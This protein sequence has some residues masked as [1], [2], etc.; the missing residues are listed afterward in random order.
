MK[1]YNILILAFVVVIIVTSCASRKHYS[2]EEY[3][4]TSDFEK[5][6]GRY[7][8]DR[9][10]LYHFFNI[11]ASD[12]YPESTNRHYR[13]GESTGDILGP[14][15]V[16]E[17]L[18][19]DSIGLDFILLS[20]NGKD[21]LNIMYRDSDFWY[22]KS[23]RG[24]IKKNYFEIVLQNKRYPFFPIISRHDVDKI[25]VGLSQSRDLLVHNYSEHWGTFLLFG[26]HAGGDEYFISL[27][28][29]SE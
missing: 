7:F 17:E 12:Y 25:R 20:F 14:T 23:Y 21:S 10:S 2:S 19:Q 22:K 18:P 15:T 3:F 29:L 13:V 11:K 16:K 28:R 1:D 24:K 9:K 8:M 4:I 26:A 27:K 5:I 6:N